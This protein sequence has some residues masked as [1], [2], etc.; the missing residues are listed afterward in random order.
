MKYNYQIV[1]YSKELG[2]NTHTVETVDDLKAW[3][4]VRGMKFTGNHKGEK[5]RAELQGH[6]QF[7]ELAGPMYNGEKD[8]VHCIRYECWE[9]YNLMSA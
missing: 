5:T 8:G 2:W 4:E 6:P 3:A 1:T 9:A 7:Y